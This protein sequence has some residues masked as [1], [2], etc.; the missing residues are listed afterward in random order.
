MK[1]LLLIIISI[2][3]VF[4]ITSCSESTNV[5][6]NS[7]DTSSDSD[8]SSESMKVE[9]K[10]VFEK[11][12]FP[13]T[14]TSEGISFGKSSWRSEW[15]IAADGTCTGY[16]FADVSDESKKGIWKQVSDMEYKFSGLDKEHWNYWKV[17]DDYKF[18]YRSDHGGAARKRDDIVRGQFF[19]D[20]WGF[21]SDGTYG[22]NDSKGTYEWVDDN[23]IKVSIRGNR[24]YSARATKYYCLDDEGYLIPEVY[25]RKKETVYG[26][27]KTM[28]VAI[29]PYFEPFNYYDENGEL[30]GFDIE[31]IKLVADKLGLNV[32]Y[33]KFDYKDLSSALINNYAHIA[34]GGIENGYFTDSNIEYTKEYVTYKADK[35]IKCC[36]MLP[37]DSEITEYI[38]KT[39]LELENSG[40]IQKLYDKYLYDENNSQEILNQ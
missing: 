28:T 4:S 2:M 33:K 38:N 14:Y 13:G 39:L 22:H 7:S 18:I 25:A 1:K 11:N 30:V 15:V 20:R 29:N 23:I 26:T 21:N 12:E 5:D 24:D 19:S 40:E 27:T 32:E 36:F 8:T 9:L 3:L 35:D 10:P 34:I 6:I 16:T 37:K 31:L 17:H